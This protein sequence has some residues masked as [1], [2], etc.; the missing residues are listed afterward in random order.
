TRLLDDA[1]VRQ[2][3]LF[4]SLAVAFLNFLAGRRG[5]HQAESHVAAEPG[6]ID[7]LLDEVLLAR[8][9]LKLEL[10]LWVGRG[11]AS[12]RSTVPDEPEKAACCQFNTVMTAGDH[13]SR[14]RTEK[15]IRPVNVDEAPRRG[16]RAGL[17]RFA[18]RATSGEHHANG[19]CKDSCQRTNHCLSLIIVAG[20]DRIL[21]DAGSGE[22]VG[23]GGC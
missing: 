2:D 6:G 10:C 15:L 13:R 21:R 5:I 1:T 12:H 11:R 8:A 19:A 18:L 7:I 16:S 20:M 3:S 23:V 9:R 14:L 4:N 22:P 17:I